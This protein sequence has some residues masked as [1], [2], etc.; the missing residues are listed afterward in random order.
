[1]AMRMDRRR[2]GWCCI[3]GDD[4]FVIAGQSG[5]IGI[6][7][8]VDG[9]NDY[10][11]QRVEIPGTQCS[12]GS[13]YKFFV[14]D[15]PGSNDLLLYFEG[16][17]AC[18]DYESCSGQLGLL[19]A[20]NP[21]GIPDDYIFQF[22]SRFVSPL[23][24]GADP[25]LP[26]ARRTRSRPKAGMSCISPIARAMCIRAT[27][28]RPTRTRRDRTRRSP[29]GTPG[30]HNTR[31]AVQYLSGR[32]PNINRMVV[33]GFSAGGVAATAAYYFE[34][35]PRANKVQVRHAVESI[36]NVT[37]TQV[38]TQIRAGKRKRLGFTIGTQ[39]PWKKAIVT[40]KEGDSIE[41]V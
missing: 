29:F 15:D 34:V 31:E 8:V 13:Q 9:G 23:M 40:L 7:D 38:R 21:N 25:G 39:P 32:F 37:V 6:E 24:N 22:K 18:W 36:F 41:V 2:I 30:F 16:G 3:L 19:G 28:C 12:D 17:G 27:T 33:S 4:R 11:W 20:A 5:A 26:S 1:M 14:H 35:H 10:P